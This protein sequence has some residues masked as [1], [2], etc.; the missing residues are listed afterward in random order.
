MAVDLSVNLNKIALLRN[1]REG[2]FPN[3]LEFGRRCLS[4]GA[5]GLTVHPRPDQRHIRSGDILPLAALLKE[6]PG[7]EFNIEGNPFASAQGSYPGFLNLVMEARPHQCT[8]VPDGNDQLTSDHGF[9][10][11]K[12]G[13]KLSPI[14]K[15]L[16]QKNIRTSLFM[17]PDPAQIAL[18]K[19]IGADRIELYTGPYA[20]AVTNNDPHLDAIVDR[21]YQAAKYAG[22]IG[23]GVNAGHDLNLANLPRFV[24]APYLLEVSI[25]HA[26]TVDALSIGWDKA[27]TSYLDICQSVNP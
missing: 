12:D 23:L 27:I 1:S 10:L 22:E 25:G 2:E 17:D 19:N 15:Q 24:N 3:L 16:R 13:E 18:A 20:W 8:L 14:L 9:D 11:R 5:S 26:L 21:Y 4:L 6:Y 7:R